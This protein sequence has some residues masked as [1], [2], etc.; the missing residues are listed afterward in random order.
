MYLKL[1]AEN[2]ILNNNKIVQIFTIG[3]KTENQI[4]N[5]NEIFDYLNFY[6]VQCLID[7]RANPMP[8]DYPEF[9]RGHLHQYCEDKNITYHWAGQQLGNDHGIGKNSRHEALIDKF[10]RDY[11]DYMETRKFQIAAAQIINMA[12]QTRLALFSDLLQLENNFRL[13]LSDYLLLQGL[14]VTHIITNNETREH[15]LHKNARRESIELIYD[16]IV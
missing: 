1:K 10:L 2:F 7:I 12:K 5:V 13:L 4:T 16:N 11:A 6:G 15:L 8:T 9:N 14:Q 3:Y